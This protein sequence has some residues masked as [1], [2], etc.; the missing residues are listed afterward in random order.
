M[1]EPRH[2]EIEALA[3]EVFGAK[4]RLLAWHPVDSREGDRVVFATLVFPARVV[5]L[6]L[7]DPQSAR[8]PL[9][10]EAAIQRRV[11]RETSVPVCEV[12]AVDDSCQRFPWRYLMTAHAPGMGWRDALARMSP[13]ARY[14]IFRQ[15][16][17]AVAALHVLGFPAF[18]EIEAGSLD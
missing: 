3:R 16:G 12:L 6:K 13:R 9:A 2:E 5:V 10:R 1:P 7:A 11:A 8:P 18:G 14:A 4:C 15:L 17:A